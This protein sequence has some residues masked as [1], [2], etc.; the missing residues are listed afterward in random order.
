MPFWCLA[1]ASSRGSAVPM[2]AR[3]SSPSTPAWSMSTTALPG[4]EDVAEALQPFREDDRLEMPGLIRQGEDAHLVAGLGAA[5]LPVEHR[6]GDAADA[7]CRPCTERQK[8]TQVW[9]RSFF[10]RSPY[11]SRG[12]PE[13]KK[14]TASYSRCRRSAA[15]Q[16]S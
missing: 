2:R 1:T 3:T 12:W 14:P 7:S 6:R 11:S 4:L 16:G 5:L 10:S 9:T 13:R 8:S 15:G